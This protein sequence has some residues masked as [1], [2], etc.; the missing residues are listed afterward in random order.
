MKILVTGGL[1]AVGALLSERLRQG[2]DEVWILD[3]AHHHGATAEFGRNNGR[4]PNL[5][6]FTPGV[7]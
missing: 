7:L 6:A 3:R 1:G 2:G 5:L 4:Q